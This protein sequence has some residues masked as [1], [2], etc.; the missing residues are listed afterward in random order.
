M[1]SFTGAF[2]NVFYGSLTSESDQ[3]IMEVAIKTMKG[4]IYSIHLY[5]C[6]QKHVYTIEMRDALLIYIYIYIYHDLAMYCVIEVLQ[7]VLVGF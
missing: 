7:C 4:T 1:K 5:T 3:S 6:V 2:G